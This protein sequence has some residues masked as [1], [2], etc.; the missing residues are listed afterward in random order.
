MCSSDKKKKE[1]DKLKP[2]VCSVIF[3]SI[4]RDRYRW[5]PN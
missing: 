4:Q 5:P 2:E 1:F 3:S